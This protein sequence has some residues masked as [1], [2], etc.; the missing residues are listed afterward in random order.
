MLGGDDEDNQ[1]KLSV[2]LNSRTSAFGKKTNVNWEKTLVYLGA[3]VYKSLVYTSSTMGTETEV[4]PL[5][6]LGGRC[7]LVGAIRHSIADMIS[8]TKSA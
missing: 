7:D 1:E 5:L 3:E 4:W 2:V 8:S 6:L